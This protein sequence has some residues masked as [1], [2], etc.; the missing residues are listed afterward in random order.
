MRLFAL[1]N[2]GLFFI[3][4]YG[5]VADAHFVEPAAVIADAGGLACVAVGAGAAV[6]VNRLAVKVQVFRGR[7]VADSDAV[8]AAAFGGLGHGKVD[9]GKPVA[10]DAVVGV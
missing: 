10:R 1:E 6:F 4:V 2:G 3:A 7:Q 8:A 9:G 5:G